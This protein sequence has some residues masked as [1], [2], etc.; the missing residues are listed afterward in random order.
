MFRKAGPADCV[1]RGGGI[2]VVLC[3][4]ERMYGTR[5]LSAGVPKPV[6][7]TAS[8]RS[9]ATFSAASFGHRCS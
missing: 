8:P 1:Y 7:P 6:I 2:R 5:E 3:A 9:T 4:I